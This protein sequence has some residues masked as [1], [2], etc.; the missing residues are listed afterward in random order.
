[1]PL[2]PAQTNSLRYQI[3]ITPFKAVNIVRPNLIVLGRCQIVFFAG[4]FTLFVTSSHAAAQVNNLVPRLERAASLIADKHI[5]E[6][7][8]ELSAILKAVPNEPIALNLLG[9]IRAQQ[10]RF[11]ESEILFIRAVS[12]DNRFVGAHM[13]L[14]YL[15][16]VTGQ[17]KKTIAQ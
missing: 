3:S 17:P 6:A 8:R 4:L 1:M 14:A 9:T 5:D 7:E 12:G 11:N 15:Y 2:Q 16:S 10:G 13:N